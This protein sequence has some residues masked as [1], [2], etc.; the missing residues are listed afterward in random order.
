MRPYHAGDSL[1]H[2]HWKAV[3]RE[4]GMQTKVFS[5]DQTEQ[6]WLGWELLPG[7]DVETRLQRICRW[8]LEADSAG[9]AYGLTIPGRQIAPALGE[10]HRRRCLEALALFG[11]PS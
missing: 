3:A 2:V 4:Q 11:E 10:S 9:I 8:V 6:L 7:L 1:R 5:G